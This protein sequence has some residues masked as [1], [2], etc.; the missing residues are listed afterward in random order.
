M[1]LAV[2]L[3][4]FG[5]AIF[6]PLHKHTLGKS[7]SCSFNNLEHQLVSPAEAAVVIAPLEFLLEAGALPAV[8]TPATGA[9]VPTRGRAPPAL[10]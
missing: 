8:L 3:L 2:L 6:S 5:V 9:A 7:T 10:S 1:F 4:F